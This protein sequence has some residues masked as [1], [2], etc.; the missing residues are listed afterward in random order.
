GLRVALV[1]QEDRDVDLV[2]PVALHRGDLVAHQERAAEEGERQGDGDDDREGHRQIAAE[3]DA[4][5]RQYELGT[6]GGSFRP[7]EWTRS[8]VISAGSRRR[9]GPGRGRGGPSPARS[10]A[11][12]SGPRCSGRASPSPRWCPS[13]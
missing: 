12:A 6:H 8:R 4:D 10:R 2:V 11:C 1:A 3:T 7:Y 13:G 5:L 9:R